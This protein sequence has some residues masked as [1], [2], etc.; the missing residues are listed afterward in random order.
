M[1]KTVFG[2]ILFFVNFCMDFQCLFLAAKLLHRP[3][4]VWRSAIFAS[5]GAVYAVAALFFSTSGAI[6]FFLDLAVCY[7]M[8]FGAFYEKRA[9]TGRVFSIFLV[10]FGVSFAVGGAMSGMASLLSHLSLP[11]SE[12]ADVS[13]GLFFLLAAVGGASTFLWG[14]LTARRAGETRA[15]LRVTL[16]GVTA[17]FSGMVDTGNLLVDPISA[18]PVVLIAAR[19]AERL[20]SPSVLGLLRRGDVSMLSRTPPETARRIRA[21]PTVGA[22]GEGMLLAIAP[23]GAALLTPRGEESVSVLIA[24]VSL[25]TGFDGAEALLPA[26]LI[27]G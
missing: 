14:R 13:S 9:G 4:H 17:E 21:C 19:A 6:A 3:F 26:C 8:C 22:T 12:S 2:D 24:P 20:L 7:L 15:M 18:K 5:V 1:E 23:D 27:S 25:H 11:V 10:Y 16:D